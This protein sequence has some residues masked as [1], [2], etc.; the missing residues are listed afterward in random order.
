METLLAILDNP[1]TPASV[2]YK[3][4]VFILTRPQLPKTGWSMPEP[5]PDPDGKKLTDSSVIEQDYDGLPGI[6]GIERDEPP[7]FEEPVPSPAPKAARA[8]ECDEMQRDSPVSRMQSLRTSSRPA[9][10]TRDTSTD[11]AMTSI[12]PLNN[13]GPS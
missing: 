8:T 2:L 7:E 6:Y 5:T 3:T 11:A 12:P 9:K 4:A 13:S 10:V 1:K